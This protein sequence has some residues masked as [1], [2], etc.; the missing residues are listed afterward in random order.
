MNVRIFWVRVMKCMYAQT[1]PWFILSSK[2]VFGGMEFEPMLTPR[3]KSP[4]PENFPRGGSN[5]WHCGQRAQTLPMSYSSPHSMIWDTRRGPVQWRH[6]GSFGDRLRHCVRL[7]TSLY[8]LDWKSSMAGNAE[9]EPKSTFD[10]FPMKQIQLNCLPRIKY[11]GLPVCVTWPVYRNINDEE[12]SLSVHLTRIY[13]SSV[14]LEWHAHEP[15][16]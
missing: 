14:R 7:R 4:L 6:T 10:T 11:F 12:S 5:L 8:S 13:I 9:E 2:R 3:E 1:R 15:K 16:M